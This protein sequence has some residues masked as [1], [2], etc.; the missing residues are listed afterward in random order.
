VCDGICNANAKIFNEV[1]AHQGKYLSWAE[2][3]ATDKKH[4]RYMQT[5]SGGCS[6]KRLLSFSRFFF[7]QKLGKA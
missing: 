6:M 1:Q 5:A 4:K 7:Y 2:Q 3:L